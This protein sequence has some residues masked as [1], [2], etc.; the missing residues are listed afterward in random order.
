MGRVLTIIGIGALNIPFIA[1]MVIITGMVARLPMVAGWDGLLPSWWSE[2]HPRFRT[3][4]KAICVVTTAM[5]LLGAL[6]LW[7]ADNQEAEQVRVG[8]GGGSLCIM[9]MLLFGSTRRLALSIRLAAAAAFLVTFIS[10]IFQIVPVGEVV[11]PKLFAF[12]VAG[13]ICA[14]NGV[15][16]YLYWRGTHPAS[17]LSI[18]S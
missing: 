6:S 8:A 7:G 2:L 9:Y 18:D 17:D 11:D 1:S 10:L 13:T 16:A 12:K 4:A 15:G 5:F 3:P 14:T